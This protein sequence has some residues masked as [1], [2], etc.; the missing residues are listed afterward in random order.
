MAEDLT[1]TRRELGGRSTGDLYSGFRRGQLP[2]RLLILTIALAG[3]GMAQSSA[4]EAM[5]RAAMDK[6]S[7]DGDLKAAI[8]QYKK[9]VASK[10]ASRE[11]VAKALIRLGACYERQGD[12]EAR[13]AYER[14]GRE[15][16]DQAESVRLAQ[17]RLAASRAP[18]ISGIAVRRVWD[19]P[20]HTDGGS[21]SA[22]GR[23]FAYSDWGNGDLA[24]RDLS[25]GENR[26]VTHM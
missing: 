1:Q 5:L 23:Y 17:A 11:V 22:D 13:K 20:G 4:T 14:V 12:I 9:I 16:G 6:E 7:V 8:E 3:A 26:L 2:M 15:F 19:Q 10:S 18:A 21:I 25:T 24:V